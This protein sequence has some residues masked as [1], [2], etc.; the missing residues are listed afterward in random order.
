M[1]VFR[2]GRTE[3]KVDMHALHIGTLAVDFCITDVPAGMAVKLGLIWIDC[4]AELMNY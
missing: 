3:L 2:S 4:Y 1:A